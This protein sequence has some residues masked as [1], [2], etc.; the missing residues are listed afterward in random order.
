MKHKLAVTCYIATATNEWIRVARRNEIQIEQTSLKKEAEK[1]TIKVE[2]AV[3]FYEGSVI[4]GKES[5]T[6]WKEAWK[7]LKKILT[8][9]QKRNKQLSL[10]EKELQNET[11][12]QYSEEESGWLK[13]NTDPRKTLSIFTSQEQMVNTRAWKK[14]RELVER[15]KC[16]LCGEHRETVHSLLPGYKKLVGKE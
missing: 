14:V 5:Y 10:E 3:S 15:N 6:G 8:D 13:C 1:A 9:G 4:I 11:L 16:R 2:V 12:V 7:K